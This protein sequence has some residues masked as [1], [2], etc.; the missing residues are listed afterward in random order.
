MIPTSFKNKL[1]IGTYLVFLFA[2]PVTFAGSINPIKTKEKTEK[3]FKS[4]FENVLGT[5]FEMKIKA[6]SNK[7]AANAE[8]IALNEINRLSKI[9]SAY[10]KNSEFSLWMQTQNRP[11]KASKELIEVLS[12]F[13][14]WKSKTNGALNPAAEVVSQI[15]KTAEKN[16]L[17]PSEESIQTAIAT[18]NQKHW[19]I[20]YTNSTI[21]HLT[22]APLMLNTF[23]KS[24]IID[25]ATKKVI[26]ETG[27]ENVVMNIGGDIL[28]A[29]NQNETIE[30]ANPKASAINDAAID[31]VRIQNQFIATS[32][33]YKRGNLIG[34]QWFSH[35]VDPRTGIPAENNISA[36]V[37][38]NNAT[39]AGALATAFNVLSVTE[40]IELA[41]Q[42][43]DAAYLLITKEGERIQSTNWNSIEIAKENLAVANNLV[44]KNDQ[45]DPAY[46]LTVNLELAQIQGGAR[47]PFVAIW[48]ENKDKASVRT[49]TVW[50]NKPRWL[51]DLRAW[52]SA[53]YSKFNAETQSINSVA[54]AT[55]SAGKYAIKWDGKTDDGEYVKNGSYI[56]NI[57][58]ARE[59]GSYQ[60][61]TQEIKVNNKA[62]KIELASNTEVASA[63]LE[64]KKK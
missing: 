42:F 16:Q 32:G 61:I 59:H 9:V 33:N 34:N 53:N 38:A 30:I 25:H 15:W 51:H 62:N 31:I 19:S 36:T 52:Y 3:F 56:I 35:I 23:V 47:R 4:Q 45:W 57:E 46:E 50:Y 7:Q 22:N 13:D 6:S 54:S 5:S 26:Q 27:I 28:V 40:C 49:L 17:L 44:V 60:L 10:D 20:D 11:I 48:V 58:V 8:K 55:R 43:P 37:V 2:I 63:S 18:V 29:G 39:D 14:S 24:Y 1:Q 12:L 64:I 21:T 41:Q